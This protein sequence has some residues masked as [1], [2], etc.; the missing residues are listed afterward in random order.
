MSLATR[1]FAKVEGFR[2]FGKRVMVGV[3]VRQVADSASL[4]VKV[5]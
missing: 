2:K 4:I 5:L 3:G 1:C